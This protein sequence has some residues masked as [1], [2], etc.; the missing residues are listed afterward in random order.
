VRVAAAETA[1]VTRGRFS[2]SRQR[3]T[4]GGHGRHR[5]RD[6]H[7]ALGS[8]F[9]ACGSR[10]PLTENRPTFARRA[11]GGCPAPVSRAPGVRLRR[12]ANPRA[13]RGTRFSGPAVHEKGRD[14]TRRVLGPTGAVPGARRSASRPDARRDIF[15]GAWLRHAR[16]GD[17]APGSGAAPASSVGF[18]GGHGLR[19][20]SP[21][22]DEAF[23]GPRAQRRPPAGEGATC[24][25]V[26]R[27]AATRK[28]PA[29]R[30]GSVERSRLGVATNA[31]D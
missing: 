18:R 15:S 2:G 12:S 9:R 26:T 14:G 21:V 31:D 7:G 17:P 27:T 28:G 6:C 20:R 30:R 23:R 8:P 10:A 19:P 22:T 3:Q 11:T 25:M 1:T 4:R 5:G 13:Q 24:H 16:S 29:P